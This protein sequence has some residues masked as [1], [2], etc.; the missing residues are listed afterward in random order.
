MPGRRTWKRVYCKVTSHSSPGKRRKTKKIPVER[1]PL[2][3]QGPSG[4]DL[5]MATGQEEIPLEA[6]SAPSQSRTYQG[7]MEKE[8]SMWDAV[9]EEILQTFVE[10][11]APLSEVC[12]VCGTM[13]ANIIH[14]LD[15]HDQS[16][17]C[18]KCVEE[19]HHNLMFHKGIQWK[20]TIQFS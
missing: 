9:M 4:L 16:Y 13:S 8:Q 17:F 7:R 1:I 19:Q 12:E 18:E 15:C 2:S 10:E 14:C 3:D 6:E 11:S 5:V 20:V